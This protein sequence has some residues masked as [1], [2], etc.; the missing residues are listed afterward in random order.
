MATATALGLEG[1][2]LFHLNL[3]HGSIEVEGRGAV[4]KRC[5][6]PLLEL[7]E[8]GPWMRLAIAASGHTLERIARAD[9]SW[10][11]R[12]FL[13]IESGRVEFIGSGDTL[14]IGPLVPAAVNRWN[15]E[16]GRATY[17]R[18][19]A[20]AP[21]I[22]LVNAMAWS[23]GLLDAYL[24]AGY[25]AL[26]MEWNDPRRAHPEWQEG[27]RHQTAWTQSPSGRRIR[28]LWTEA[29]LQQGF[30]RAA[31]G[32]L[33]SARFVDGVLA[34]G[35]PRARH[36]FLYAGAAEVFDY[37][38]GRA[39]AADGEWRRIFELCEALHA[40]GLEFTTPQHVLADARYEP[41][42]TLE[43]SAASNPIPLAH[44][45]RCSVTRWALS[46]WEDVGLNARCFAR[47]KELQR[48]GG[49]ARDWQLLCRAWGA[50]LRANLT[51]KRWRRLARSLPEVRPVKPSET[52][53]HEGPLR[54]RRVEWAGSRLAVGTEGVRAVLNLRRGLALDSL[55]LRHAG[56]EPL[57]GTLA[58]EHL[59]DAGWEDAALGAH[60]LFSGH[61]VLEG[62]GAARVTD[63]A[64]VE[65]E[66]EELAHCVSVRARVPTARG[67][68]PKE[69]RVHA[70]R[71]E[72]RY[73]FS[74]WGK[75]PRG[76]LRTG[77]LT[78]LDGAF[79]DELW[80]SCTN[81]GPRERMRLAP[82]FD[83]ARGDPRRGSACAAF[84]AS[85]GWIAIDDGRIGFEVSWPQEEA[86]SLP[87]VTCR[88]VSGKRLVR[89]Q[90][91]L[92]ELDETSR[93]GAPLHDFRLSIRPY[94]NRR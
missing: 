35:G 32:E 72:L 2:L 64:P 47:A 25:E 82:D 40:R 46:G 3:N 48:V 73:G 58:P 63:L 76:S 7:A 17:L 50:D 57:V 14:L 8:G 39:E 42:A 75:R 4:V 71:I 5:Y 21:R 78:L 1:T 86:A 6:G 51:E 19:L 23:Q 74:A 62:P 33:E 83:H 10:I 13:L 43:L 87:L 41:A 45:P 49:S 52:G 12:L 85:D 80:V 18:L 38:P 24:D 34:N 56:P 44:Q 67:P 27:W 30:Q 53:F 81:G 54:S 36:A 91:T 70:Q 61:T 89:L 20:R 31:T 66:V 28:I 90:F 84:G 26:I 77:A 11:P 16:L 60:D 29:H 94:R 93:P 92:A 22:A 9:P 55:V 59:G 37:R 68:L 15:Q 69:V 79:G 88:H 65:P